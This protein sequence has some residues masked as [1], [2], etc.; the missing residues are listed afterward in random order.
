MKIGIVTDYDIARGGGVEESI[1]GLIK[2]LEGNEIFLCCPKIG[3]FENIEKLYHSKI[4]IKKIYSIPPFLRKFTRGGFFT[5]VFLLLPFRRMIKREKLDLIID[6][7]GGLVQKFLPKNLEKRYIVWKLSIITQP[8]LKDI[9]K[10]P[11]LWLKALWRTFDGFLIKKFLSPGNVN[12]YSIDEYT[13]YL[14]KKIWKI[15]SKGY[16][17]SPIKFNE[18]KTNKKKRKNKFVVVGRFSPEKNYDFC[19]DVLR[20]LKDLGEK[21]EMTFIGACKNEAEKKYLGLL[22]NKKRRY[23][24]DKVIFIPNAPFSTILRKLKEASIFFHAQKGISSQ[25]VVTEAMAAGCIPVVRAE[26]G[27]WNEVLE[28]GKY[29]FGY[30]NEKEAVD[31]LRKLLKEGDKNLKKYRKLAIKKAKE[32]SEE[33]FKKEVLKIVREYKKI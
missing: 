17:F 30:K 7:D 26:G 23:G 31:I 22:I 1:V 8:W 3:K 28:K 10:E 21:V 33:S 16:L 15:E 29:G 25:I 18:L 12:I 5:R 27:S 4:R 19:L 14:I 9:W 32:Y 20:K 2:A 6:G 13:N 11:K 24:L